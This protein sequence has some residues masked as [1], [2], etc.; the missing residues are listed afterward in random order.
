[1]EAILLR[2]WHL[3][4]AVYNSIISRM[5]DRCLSRTLASD[6]RDKNKT[7]I[8]DKIHCLTTS[9]L[10]QHTLSKPRVYFQ[11]FTRDFFKV[12]KAAIFFAASKLAGKLSG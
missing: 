6:Q 11:L 3:K 7:R 2:S 4:H 9:S 10:T 1:M 5:E 12:F 8:R